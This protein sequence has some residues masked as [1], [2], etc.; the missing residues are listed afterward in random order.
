LKF[1]H[2][3]FPFSLKRS[4]SFDFSNH[5]IF[6]LIYQK[7]LKFKIPFK[8]EVSLNKAEGFLI[9]I[10]IRSAPQTISLEQ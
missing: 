5:C 8:H 9:E 3:S 4:K 6:S 2:L 1:P 10:S 7:P